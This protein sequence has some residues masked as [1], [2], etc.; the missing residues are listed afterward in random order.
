M[1]FHIY[2]NSIDLHMLSHGRMFWNN[3]LTLFNHSFTFLF[4]PQNPST[5]GYFST[6][7][8]LEYYWIS[9]YTAISNRERNTKTTNKNSL[10]SISVNLVVPPRHLTV[11]SRGILPPNLQLLPYWTFLLLLT[12]LSF[13]DQPVLLL[14]L[15]SLN[16]VGGCKKRNFT[17]VLL[18]S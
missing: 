15:C 14:S 13:M 17:K 12:P 5:S 18:M 1:L 6:H 7:V 8:A 2:I 11:A 16:R 9:V 10:L 4:V 3:T